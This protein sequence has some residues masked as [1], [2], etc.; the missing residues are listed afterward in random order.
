MSILFTC[1]HCGKQTNVADEFAGRSGPC[2]GCGKTITVP[3]SGEG[4][5]PMP[6]ARSRG[7]PVAVVLAIVLG[8]VVVGGVVLAFLL[9]P[10]V[11]A[12][13]EAA[14]RARCN[15]NLKQI[16]L[17]LLSYESAHH[18]FPPADSAEKEG[19][20]GM[21]WRVA[22]L[23]YLDQPAIFQLYDRHQRW[24]SPK[25]RDI[26][27]W[28]IR[29]Y[30]C[31]SDPMG[32]QSRE[33]SYVMLVGPG[34]VAGLDERDRNIAYISAHAGTTSTILAVE[35]PNSGIPWAEPRDLTVAEFI[36]R[37]KSR[38]GLNHVGGVHVAMCDGSVHFL[39][40]SISPDLLRAM[41]NPNR[42]VPIHESDL[43]Q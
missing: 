16:A 36:K 32:L 24:N 39:S 21:S 29:E 20:P 8:V 11:G 41:A 34:T 38:K 30:R 18:H 6:P 12:V 28:R 31:P 19:Q 42:R 37:L 26:A 15:N 4:F 33:T 9:F 43:L 1:P 3:P 5:F 13:R 17:A 14:N 7:V 40:A 10:A 27:D 22:I 23:P 2:A 35:A 25:N